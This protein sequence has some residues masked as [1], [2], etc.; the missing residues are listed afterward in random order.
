[1]QR[2]RPE[3]PFLSWR[4]MLYVLSWINITNDLKAEVEV[5]INNLIAEKKAKRRKPK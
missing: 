5:R 2:E 1:V 4:E 3:L